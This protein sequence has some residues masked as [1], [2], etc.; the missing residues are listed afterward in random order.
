MEKHLESLQ[1]S[2]HS[3]KIADH[4]LTIT[5]PIIKDKRLLMKSLDSI[6]ESIVYMINAVLQYDYLWKRINLSKNASENF[7]IFL[8]KCARRYDLDSQDLQNI[9]EIILLAEKHK[10]APIEFLR[11]DKVIILSDNLNTLPIDTEILKKQLNI[12]KSILAKIASILSK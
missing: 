9:E 12:T 11:R 2:I 4:I 10:K 3:L 5:Y 1:K 6:Y 8:R 7:E